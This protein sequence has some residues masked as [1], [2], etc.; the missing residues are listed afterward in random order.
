M[1][2]NENK[3]SNKNASSAIF[4]L[5]FTAMIIHAWITFLSSERKAW[6]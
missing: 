1:D 5:S 6:R 2:T 3:N 4:Y